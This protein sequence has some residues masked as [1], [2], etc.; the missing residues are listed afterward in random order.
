MA[1]ILR[2]HVFMNSCEELSSLTHESDNVSTDGD[3][4]SYAAY[5]KL[6]CVFVCYDWAEKVRLKSDGN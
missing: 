4:I 1:K 3:V 5:L 6:S 2:L